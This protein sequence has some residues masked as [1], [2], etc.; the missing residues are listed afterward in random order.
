MCIK[1][2]RTFLLISIA[3]FA[4]DQ[5]IKLY[6]LKTCDFKCYENEYFSLVLVYNKGVAFSF[7]YFLG[8]YLKYLQ[9]AMVI[10]VLYF[11]TTPKNYILAHPIS[12][13]LVFGGGISNIFDRFIRSGVVD[14]FYWHYG[15]DFAIF[16]FADVMIN[17]GITL[18][19]I[20]IIFIKDSAKG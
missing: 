18:L 16:N 6:F 9:I 17:L 10:I 7:L 12:F 14:Y 13:A 19:I 2:L 15:F 20:Q 4:I 11:L 5:S 3:I 8:D 1:K